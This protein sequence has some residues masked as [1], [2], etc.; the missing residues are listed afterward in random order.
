M[1]R[2]SGAPRGLLEEKEGGVRR[3]SRLR[4]VTSE[5]K[6]SVLNTYHVKPVFIFIILRK[7]QTNDQICH[8]KMF[9]LLTS[10]KFGNHLSCTSELSFNVHDPPQCISNMKQVRIMHCSESIFVFS[11][12]QWLCLLFCTTSCYCV[13]FKKL[14]KNVLIK[15]KCF[16]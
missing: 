3:R 11:T 16:S 9:F 4:R 15:N 1:D 13:S 7:K 6:S 12:S 10:I 14:I 8:L 5:M 2:G